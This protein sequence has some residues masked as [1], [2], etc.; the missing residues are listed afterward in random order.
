MTLMPYLLPATDYDLRVLLVIPPPCCRSLTRLAWAPS[1]IQVYLCLALGGIQPCSL[2]RKKSAA[3]RLHAHPLRTFLV[4]MLPVC[5]L[6]ASCS[7]AIRLQ[8]VTHTDHQAADSARVTAQSADESLATVFTL[9]APMYL[10]YVEHECWPT[11]I[12]QLQDI[13]RQFDIPFDLSSYSS[14]NMQELKDGRLRVRFELAPPSQAT[15]E[16]TLSKPDV[17]TQDHELAHRSTMAV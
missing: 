14:V 3:M 11:S 4:L 15:G 17:D 8:G 5:L 16:F 6:L 10:Y 7:Q 2:A 9:A 13:A 12:R 1:F